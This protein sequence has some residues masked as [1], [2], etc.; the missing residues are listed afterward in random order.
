MRL[1]T[2]P[3][4]ARD[5]LLKVTDGGGEGAKEVAQEQKSAFL[6]AFVEFVEAD[7]VVLAVPEFALKHGMHPMHEHGHE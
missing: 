3:E 7:L 5:F 1:Q 2:G 4:Q 6:K